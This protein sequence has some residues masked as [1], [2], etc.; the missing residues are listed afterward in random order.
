MSTRQIS[1]DVDADLIDPQDHRLVRIPLKYLGHSPK[2]VRQD[3][4]LSTAFCASLKAELQVIVTVMPIPDDYERGPGE[5][6]HRFWV[7][8]GNR[9]LAGA[10]KI[11][12]P[13]LMCL[14]DFTKSADDPALFTDQV[15][16]ND[17]DFRHGLTP[18]ERAD[19]LFGAYQAGASK[20]EIRKR[21]GRTRKEI[22]DALATSRLSEQTRVYAQEM[23]HDWTLDELAL[24]SEFE[25]D[26]ES[27]A[28]IKTAVTSWGHTVRYAVEYRRKKLAEDKAH[29]AVLAEL[30]AAGVTVTESEPAKAIQLERLARL[31]DGL[32]LEAHGDC[33]GHGAFFYR[34][35][36]DTPVFYCSTPEVHGH[37]PPSYGGTS[38]AVKKDEIPRKVVI[39]GN[40]AWPAACVVRQEW[41]A[42]FLAR[43]SAPKPLARWITRVLNDMPAP[44]RN[45]LGSASLS[46]LYR[47]LGG[48]QDLDKALAT[49]TTGRLVLLQFLP[50]AV[51]WEHELSL[52]S[53]DCK[54]TWRPGAYSPCSTEDAATWLRFL[55]NELGPELGEAAY[56]PCPIERALIDGVPYRGD[57]VAA[58]DAVSQGDASAGDSGEPGV[59]ADAAQPDVASTGDDFQPE[60]LAEHH[61]HHGLDDERDDELEAALTDDADT[62]DSPDHLTASANVPDLGDEAC[63]GAG[64]SGYQADPADA[65]AA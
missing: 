19:A 61:H 18:F 39:E 15:V 34:W 47:K 17:D 50:I 45:R 51:A 26:P 4:R 56:R 21:T 42:A 57:T 13:D 62:W 37:R 11:E 35:Q 40:R 55:V 46:S 8:K 30:E 5:E 20:T 48:P 25:G 10:R 43:K 52:A 60:S 9:R 7:I 63:D 54:N 23:E 36:R 3:Y 24:L 49:A 38:P 1:D 22:A 33:P 64:L 12:L 53:N 16:E 32:D 2:N 41:L 44:V 6:E 28:S 14:I 31:V 27:L 59:E 58:Q 65:L 29:A